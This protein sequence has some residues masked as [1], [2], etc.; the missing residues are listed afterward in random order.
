[1]RGFPEEIVKSVI[2]VLKLILEDRGDCSGFGLGCGVLIGQIF[3]LGGVVVAY[4][5]IFKQIH[6]QAK[7]ALI[8]FGEIILEVVPPAAA[9]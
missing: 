1:M 5:H 7:Q 9:Q 3:V 2:Y 4:Q 8:K 6:L